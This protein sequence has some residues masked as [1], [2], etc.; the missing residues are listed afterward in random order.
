VI[1]LVDGRGLGVPL[2]WC[3]RLEDATPEQRADW[4]LSGPI[5]TGEGIH[6]EAVDEDISVPRLLELPC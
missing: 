6:W 4:R 2:A 3:S 5:G 1:D